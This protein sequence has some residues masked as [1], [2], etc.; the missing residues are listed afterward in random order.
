MIVSVASLLGACA[1]ASQSPIIVDVASVSVNGDELTYHGHISHA[2]NARLFILAATSVKQLRRLVVTSQGGNVEAGMELGEW[3]FAEGLDVYV[4]KYCT[5]SCANYVFPAGKRKFLDHSAMLF[6]HGGA[7][8]E[9]SDVE[10]L[11]DE[12]DWPKEFGDC[13]EARMRALHDNT[14]A[15][16]K[17]RE[18]AFFAMIE[19]DQ[20][21]T[22]LGQYPEYHCRGG[23]SGWYYSIQDMETMGIS[24]I[25]VY[26][27]VWRPV[28]PSPDV[29]ICQV[30]LDQLPN[31][32][33]EQPGHE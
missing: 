16:I 18:A 4:P 5:S 2:A 6:W 7:L 9:Q 15:R 29:K 21:I 28:M 19:V 10:S 11:C 3:V 27:E 12:V 32:A 20:K 33:L 24:D 1:A 30:N 17:V 22:I 23:Y 14:L 13:D 26:G 25:M 31:N 8:Q